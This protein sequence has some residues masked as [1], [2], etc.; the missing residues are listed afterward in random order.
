[1]LTRGVVLDLMGTLPEHR[2][3]G[4]ASL[5]LEWA[6][7]FADKHGLV[8]NFDVEGEVSSI[9]GKY[10]WEKK[11]SFKVEGSKGKMLT[12]TVVVREPKQN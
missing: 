4:A 6:A 3:Q 8:S 1:M 5:M 7:D 9:C 2:R 11:E 12:F 10:G